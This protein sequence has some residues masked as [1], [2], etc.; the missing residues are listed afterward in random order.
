MSD[1]EESDS[2]RKRRTKK[3]KKEKSTRHRSSRSSSDTESSYERRRRKKRKKKD[4]KVK[5]SRKTAEEVVV[6]KSSSTRTVDDPPQPPSSAYGLSAA[7][8]DTVGTAPA[9]DHLDDPERF[10]RAQRMVPMTRE[11]Y[12][13]QQS[14]IRE[15]YDAETGRYRLVR[16]T[17]EIIERIVSKDAHAAINRQATL[18]DG[19]SFAR[20]VYRTAGRR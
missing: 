3:R 18:G 13:Q 12:E 7:T 11:Q 19:A 16:G 10:E 17:G 4:K 8:S 1:S 9:T 6:Q 5:K 20:S 2:D 14:V 15:V